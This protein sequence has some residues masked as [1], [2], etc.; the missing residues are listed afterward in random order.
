MSR[1]R[2]RLTTDHLRSQSMVPE[3]EKNM[4]NVSLDRARSSVVSTESSTRSRST[5]PSS[6]SLA[7][8]FKNDNNYQLCTRPDAGG[9]EGRKTEL[10][11]NF[12]EIDIDYTSGAYHYDIDIVFLYEKKDGDKAEAKARKEYK[13]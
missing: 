8:N 12:Y 2:G 13:K 3:L 9:K 7:I 11:T 10:E 4:S 6:E 1:G 5:A